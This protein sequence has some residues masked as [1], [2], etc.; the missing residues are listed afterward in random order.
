DLT[1]ANLLAIAAAGENIARNAILN[2]RASA[3]DGIQPAEA[4]QYDLVI[5][6]PPFHIGG[7]VDYEVAHAFIERA[8]RVLAPGG[9]FLLVAN[10]FIRYDQ[11]MRPA[12]ERV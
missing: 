1:D 6:N 12:F 10:H 9:R 3:S 8:R 11:L 7:T 4:Q 2:A 5:T